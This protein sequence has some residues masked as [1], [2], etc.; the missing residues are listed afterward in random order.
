MNKL[1]LVPSPFPLESGRGMKSYKW[2]I[3]DLEK[4]FEIDPA[5]TQFLKISR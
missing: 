5:K 4:K 2:E 1:N 3:Y